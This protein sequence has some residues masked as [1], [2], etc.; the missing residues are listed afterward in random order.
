[1]MMVKFLNA[2]NRWM[3]M[4]GPHARESDVMQRMYPETTEASMMTAL[5]QYPTTAP[6]TQRT[7]GLMRA[8]RQRSLMMLG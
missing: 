5:I 2:Y 4:T 1:M 7:R 3:E 8:E 6:L